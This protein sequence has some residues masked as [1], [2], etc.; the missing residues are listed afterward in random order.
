MDEIDAGN[1]LGSYPEWVTVDAQASLT[2]LDMT[3]SEVVETK[4]VGVE[5][6]LL[7][8]LEKT[9]RVLRGD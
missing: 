2:D 4:G 6:E 1:Y 8:K 7:R 3:L 5:A 9:R